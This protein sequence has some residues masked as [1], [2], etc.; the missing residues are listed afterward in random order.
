MDLEWIRSFLVIVE[1][2]SLNAAAERLRVAQSSLTR[3]VQ[4]LE[5]E[6][7]GTLLERSARGVS[8]T[9]AGRAF[10]QSMEAVMDGFDQAVERTRER[11]RGRTDLLR[12]GYLISASSTLVTPALAVVRRE[13]P[14]VRFEL[15]DLSPGE[16]LAALRSG[17]IDF[18]LL[19]H[20][21]EDISRD[22]HVRAL[23]E[24]GIVAAVSEEH[25]LADAVTITIAQ[26]RE[27]LFVGVPDADL[28][29]YRQWVFSLC[30]PAGFRP[31]FTTDTDSLSAGFSRIVLENTVLLLGDY[32]RSL[33]VP[34]VRFVPIADAGACWRLQV[35]WQPGRTPTIVETLVVALGTTAGAEGRTLR[36]RDWGPPR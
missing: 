25:A 13:H 1:E 8:P 6:L 26:L 34:G 19:G 27:S 16:Q 11:M 32:A 18:A 21:G 2:G 29:G 3:R 23:A 24:L 22:F 5:H 10:A 12:I 9:A 35:A 17:K 28:P 4:A 15:H 14:E 20:I 33:V 36:S 31:R 7:G 30:R